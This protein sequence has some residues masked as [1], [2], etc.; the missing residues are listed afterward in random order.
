MSRVGIDIGTTSIKCCFLSN[1]SSSPSTILHT[2]QVHTADIIS[3]DNKHEQ[4]AQRILSA[5][6]TALV[7]LAEKSGALILN[8]NTVSVCCQMHG[9]MLWNDEHDTTTL[10][11]WQDHR[12]SDDFLREIR[13]SEFSDDLHAGYG[14]ATLAWLARNTPSELKKYKHCGTVADYLVF[15]LCGL[16]EG[17]I[18]DHNAQSWGLFNDKTRNWDN[19]A[20]NTAGVTINLPK[21]VNNGNIIGCVVNEKFSIQKGAQ[22]F[23]PVGDLQASVY[24]VLGASSGRVFN[25]GTASQIVHTT[26][27]DD[28]GDLPVSVRRTLYTDKYNLVTAASLNGG[29]SMEIVFNLF[30]SLT[31][32]LHYDT[33]MELAYEKRNTD[34]RVCPVF[35][36]ERH[37]TGTFGSFSNVTSDNFTVGDISAAVLRGVVENLCEMMGGVQTNFDTLYA[38]G[39]AERP[40]L[41]HYLREIMGDFVLFDKDVTAAYGAILFDLDNMK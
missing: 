17:V 30:S 38:V 10:V 27:C 16:R 33:V 32:D 37:D 3:S 36:G 14:S 5:V 7:A 34:L 39:I 8:V 4:C 15:V 25:Y 13:Y 9:V 11:T 21:I 23:I 29:N 31:A 18:S 24:S 12:C 2:K 41:Q 26:K 19:R 6:R 1:P 20:L 40:I 35:F 28:F 22:V